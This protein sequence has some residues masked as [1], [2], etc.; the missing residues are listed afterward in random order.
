MSRIHLRRTLDPLGRQ[1]DLDD[2]DDSSSTLL[3][4]RCV[5]RFSLGF[6]LIIGLRNDIDQQKQ[7]PSAAE[8]LEKIPTSGQ[9]N[10]TRTIYDECR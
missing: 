3:T 8:Y 5:H 2:D 4:L 9:L 7:N 6:E 10:V 1:G